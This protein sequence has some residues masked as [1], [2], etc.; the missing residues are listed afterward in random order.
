MIWFDHD[1]DLESRSVLSL[2]NAFRLNLVNVTHSELIENK[3]TY[4]RL[5]RKNNFIEKSFP[6]ASVPLCVTLVTFWWP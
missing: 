3:N 6:I 2:L 4:A 5:I 1:N